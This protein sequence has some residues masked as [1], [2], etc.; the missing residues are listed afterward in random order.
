[1]ANRSNL[2]P[3]LSY[4]DRANIGN[5]KIEGMNEDLGLSSTQYNT[6]LSIF[7]VT[8][9]IFEMP[10]NYVLDKFFFARPEL[11]LGIITVGWGIMMTMVSWRSNPIPTL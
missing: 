5:A 9:I 4:V 3:V 8:Y 2:I 1:M 6:V 10:S 7:F 11:W